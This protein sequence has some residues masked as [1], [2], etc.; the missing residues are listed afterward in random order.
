MP[1]NTEIF[2]FVAGIMCS[3]SMFPQIFHSWVY[4]DTKSIAWGMLAINGISLSM[5]LVYGVLIAHP[6][7][8][9]TSAVSLLAN[10]GL[11]TLKTVHE[12]API[13]DL[14]GIRSMSGMSAISDTASEGLLEDV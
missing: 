7:I 3:M 13:E 5:Y 4:K 9:S 10:A 1:D 8:Y 12:C 11:A 6:A 2:G 14:D